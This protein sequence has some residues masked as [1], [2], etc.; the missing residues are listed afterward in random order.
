MK[1]DRVARSLDASVPDPTDPVGRLL[2]NVVAMVAE[3][4]ADARRARV[5]RSHCARAVSR[6]RGGCAVGGDAVADAMRVPRLAAPL[7]HADRPAPRPVS[8]SAEPGPVALPARPERADALLHRLRAASCSAL[9]DDPA[10]IAGAAAD[11][12]LDP[13]KLA[14]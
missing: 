9:L 3:F 13:L 11:V 8:A 12:G 4:E 2:F 14:P 5:C 10:G 1:L 7:P 6:S